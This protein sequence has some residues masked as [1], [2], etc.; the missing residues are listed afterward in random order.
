MRIG[1]RHEKGQQAV[2]DQNMMTEKSWVM[3][4]DQTDKEQ[5]LWQL[6]ICGSK[7]IL[8]ESQCSNF[9]GWLP[10]LVSNKKLKLNYIYVVTVGAQVQKRTEE[11]FGT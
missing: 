10:F 11:D 3:M 9:K 2:Q 6:V 7:N 1:K 4:K 5:H 8:A